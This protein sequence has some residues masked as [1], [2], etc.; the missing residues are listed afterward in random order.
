MSSNYHEK[1]LYGN[2]N[3]KFTS[4]KERK[5]TL[6]KQILCQKKQSNTL[7]FSL[8]YERLFNLNKSL[9]HSFKNV[10]FEW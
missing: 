5:K 7:K 6:Y 8:I 10:V 2:R 4:L 9:F 3:F 1:K